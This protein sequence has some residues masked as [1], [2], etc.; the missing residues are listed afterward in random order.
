VR[1]W[2]QRKAILIPAGTGK[3]RREKSVF[4]VHN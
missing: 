2:G 3:R 4:L 1:G